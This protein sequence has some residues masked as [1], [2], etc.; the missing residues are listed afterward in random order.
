M[1][2][3]LA[4]AIARSAPI[5]A[6]AASRVSVVWCDFGGVLTPPIAEAIESIV[7]ASGIPW[8]VLRAAIQRVSANLG[9]SGMQPLEL[10]RIS[11]AEWGQLVSADL[12][13][14]YRSA[15]D[16]GNWGEYWYSDRP[17]NTQL[18]AELARLAASGVRVGMLTNSVL[19]WEGPRAIMLDGSPE[20]SA[21]VR[22]HELGIAKPDLRIFRY[23]DTQ[24]DPREGIAVLIDDMPANCAA[25]DDHGW[26]SIE[27]STTERTIARL[28]LLV[29]PSR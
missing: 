5:S 26:Q 13:D 17:L 4:S 2:T 6:G 9:L 28:R 15:I 1:I 8:P 16:L 29:P 20:F 22:S 14:G 19:E 10:G 21:V 23:A 7:S 24:L 3:R 27:H 25:A 11:Q 18:V 12:P